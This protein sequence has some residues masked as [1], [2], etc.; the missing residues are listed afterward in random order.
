MPWAGVGCAA[1]RDGAGLG[2]STTCSETRMGVGS[3]VPA[4]VRAGRAAGAGAC[5]RGVAVSPTATSELPTGR[6]VGVG[7]GFGTAQA[8]SASASRTTSCT[9]SILMA[10]APRKS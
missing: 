2:V 5:G 7:V 9:R 8:P 3:G 4:G 6:E 1:V 10:I